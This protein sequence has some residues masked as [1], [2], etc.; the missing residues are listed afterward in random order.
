MN[1]SSHYVS[2]APSS[3]NQAHKEEGDLRGFNSLFRL[4]GQRGHPAAD[5]RDRPG[6][7]I[8][9]QAAVLPAAVAA[10]AV[11]VVAAWLCSEACGG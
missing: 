1:K 4:P 2:F 6:E 5:A 9:A 11:A 3:S 8:A 7:A 10:A